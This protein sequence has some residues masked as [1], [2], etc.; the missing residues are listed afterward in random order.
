MSTYKEVLF[1]ICTLGLC[2]IIVKIVGVVIT[3]VDAKGWF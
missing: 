3:I 2:Y 1:M